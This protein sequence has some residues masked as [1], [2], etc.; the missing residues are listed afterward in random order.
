MIRNSVKIKKET[1]KT[2]T[3]P[4]ASRRSRNVSIKAIFYCLEKTWGAAPQDGA[5]PNC[6]RAL[7]KWPWK[8][9][10]GRLDKYKGLSTP[11]CVRG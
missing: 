3:T 2:T 1:K 7:T 5:A 4:W 10:S 11:Y 6:L 9:P 8:D